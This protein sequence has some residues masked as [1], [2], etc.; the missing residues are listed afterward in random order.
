MTQPL[1]LDTV[2]SEFSEQSE[3]WVLQ[4][5][6]Q[7]TF[8]VIPDN[9]FPGRRPVRFFMSQADADRMLTEVLKANPSLAGERITPVSV[10]LLQALRGIAADKT[11]GH[12]DSFVIHS[13]NEVFEFLH[14]H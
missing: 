11:P 1:P 6:R 2:L 5:K 8:L 12:A 7:G 10:R 9:R 3:A 14:Q 13:P 4:S